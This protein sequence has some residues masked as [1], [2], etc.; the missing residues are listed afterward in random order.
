MPGPWRRAPRLAPSLR[1]RGRA[2]QVA[3][4]AQVRVAARPAPPQRRRCRGGR[5][6]RRIR[7]AAPAPGPLGLVPHRPLRARAADPARVPAVPGQDPAPGP[8]AAG[9]RGG[10]SLQGRG[11]R[12]S[13][14]AG[15]AGPRCGCG[16]GLRMAG[17][18]GGSGRPRGVASRSGDQQPPRCGEGPRHGEGGPPRA[19]VAGAR[20]RSGRGHRPRTRP[21]RECIPPPAVQGSQG[22][23]PA[24]LGA[25][26]RHP[27]QGAQGART[28][29]LLPQLPLAARRASAS[30]PPSAGC[31]ARR[32]PR[33]R[34]RGPQPPAGHDNHVGGADRAAAGCD[35]LGGGASL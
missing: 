23:C 10:R 5:I 25:H 9:R 27:R 7:A 14:R 8:G 18:Q 30:V 33:G 29:S 12:A 17:M 3:C 26:E 28:Q 31:D 1:Q 4:R 2:V 32:A 24:L 11:P 35:P 21:R 22:R 13:G 19:G 20:I 16:C 6:L 34:G 15:R